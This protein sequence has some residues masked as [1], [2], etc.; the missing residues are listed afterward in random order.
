VSP[1][2]PRQANNE[3]P[4][5]Q[6]QNGTLTAQD[7]DGAL[8]KTVATLVEVLAA[9]LAEQAATIK[10]QNQQISAHANRTS[11]SQN[12]PMANLVKAQADRQAQHT[13]VLQAQTDRQA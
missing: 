11:K 13:A 4:P 5:P 10:A 7:K 12:D 1:P 8:V 2:T 3:R 6:L 9:Q